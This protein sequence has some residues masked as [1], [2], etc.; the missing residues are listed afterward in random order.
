MK[1]RK[2]E[3]KRD[4][5]KE[6]KKEKKTTNEWK[7]E[8]E[9]EREKAWRKNENGW[10]APCKPCFYDHL[11]CFVST[12]KYSCPI[13]FWANL[14]ANAFNLSAVISNSLYYLSLEGFM[15]LWSQ[16]LLLQIHLLAS[17]L[18]LNISALFL[19]FHM[20]DPLAWC[21]ISRFDYIM[22]AWSGLHLLA[23]VSMR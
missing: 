13:S 15:I 10:L 17:A 8:W 18:R 2:R 20:S 3:R 1:E 22:F 9:R 14:A 6:R 23:Q 19:H 11:C 5:K 4:R 21:R 16:K 12:K 7:R